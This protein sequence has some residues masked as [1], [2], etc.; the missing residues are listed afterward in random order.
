MAWCLVKHGDNFTFTF[1]TVRDFLWKQK[2]I[3]SA[4]WGFPCCYGT[5]T[6]MIVF[7]PGIG[8]YSELLNPLNSFRS[9]FYN[10]GISVLILSPAYTWFTKT[11]SSIWDFQSK[12]LYEFLISPMRATYSAHCILFDLMTLIISCEVCLSFLNPAIGV[13]EFLFRSGYVSHR[14]SKP[15]LP[16]AC[17]RRCT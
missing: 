5:W 3:F 14:D 10:I 7:K 4:E 11:V 17:L 13:V 12:Y 16:I 8:F 6:F 2:D 1:T 9:C 15:G